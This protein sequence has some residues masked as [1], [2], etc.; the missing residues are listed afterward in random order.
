MRLILQPMKFSAIANVGGGEA[1]AAVFWGEGHGGVNGLTGATHTHTPSIIRSHP[2]PQYVKC[3]AVTASAAAT[4]PLR[5][6]SRQ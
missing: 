1:G 6:S 3:A 4:L 2:P 5:R